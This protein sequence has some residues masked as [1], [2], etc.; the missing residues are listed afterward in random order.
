MGSA[1]HF[2]DIENAMVSDR[3]AVTGYAQ[4]GMDALKVA[5]DPMQN[6]PTAPDV[7]TYRA[8]LAIYADLVSGC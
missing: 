1:S 4:L 3:H 5:E 2:V 6:L 7:A 8:D